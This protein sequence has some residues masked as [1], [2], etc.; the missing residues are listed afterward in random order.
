M[1]SI[2]I[3]SLEI[4]LSETHTK[5]NTSLHLTKKPDTKKESEKE[6]EACTGGRKVDEMRFMF[7]NNK[8]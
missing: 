8:R 4:I 6:R 1:A 7:G 3:I 2:M 5:G